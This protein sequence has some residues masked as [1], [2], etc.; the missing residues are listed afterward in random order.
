MKEKPILMSG[1]MVR[2]ILDGRKTQTRR[3]VKW[4][5]VPKTHD[6][7]F[8][9][10]AIIEGWPY[11]S[12]RGSVD[13]ETPLASPYGKPGDRLW[14][15]ETFMPDPYIN[16][17][18]STIYRATEAEPERYSGHNWKPSIFMPR[19]RSRITLEITGVRAERL[20]EISANDATA[21]GVEIITSI[22]H[23][24]TDP[25]AA[26]RVLWESINGKGSWEKNPWVWCISFK[27][28]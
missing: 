5:T 4:S 11:L 23:G 27:R 3:V 10:Y 26:Y 20:N 17:V 19:I 18:A 7:D 6:Y 9:P 24:S 22:D 8:E 16:S 1:A 15:K 25:V 14:V 13:T 2:A 28:I 21:E 12:V